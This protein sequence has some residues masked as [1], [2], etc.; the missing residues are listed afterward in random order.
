MFVNHPEYHEFKT[1]L[2]KNL[3]S[4]I[5]ERLEETDLMSPP[6]LCRQQG[7]PGEALDEDGKFAGSS[8]CAGH[9]EEQFK[10]LTKD[11]D[12]HHFLVEN[13]SDY[14]PFVNM[15]EKLF[16]PNSRLLYRGAHNYSESNPKIR[17]IFAEGIYEKYLSPNATH[18]VTCLSAACVA[19]I[20]GKAK[21]GDPS[22]YLTCQVELKVIFMP[23]F[24]QNFL[25]T[26]AFKEY[27]ATR[28]WDKS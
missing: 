11:P 15:A 10:A 18:P 1:T 24:K 12:V 6:R 26:E 14:D 3:K 25:G 16:P 22:C 8:Y 21:T 23:I 5:N 9:H 20:Q 7:C 28:K 19:E 27:V 17:K 13:G 4:L 2:H